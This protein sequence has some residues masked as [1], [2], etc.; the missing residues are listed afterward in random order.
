MLAAYAGNVM[1]L[2]PTTTAVLMAVVLHFQTECHAFPQ[3]SATVLAGCTLVA[4][5]EIAFQHDTSPCPL[6]WISAVHSNMISN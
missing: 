6:S 1:A 4:D 5:E 2:V 3:H